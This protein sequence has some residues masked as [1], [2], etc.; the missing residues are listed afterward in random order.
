[1][2]TPARHNSKKTRSGFVGSVREKIQSEQVPRL[3]L[4]FHTLS[5]VDQGGGFLKELNR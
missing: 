4:V 5:Q 3:S 1:M 2:L